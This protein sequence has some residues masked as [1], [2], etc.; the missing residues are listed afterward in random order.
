M[1]V[2]Q[3]IT[4]LSTG[5][6]ETMLLKLLARLHGGDMEC[7]VISLTD[8]GEIGPRIEALGVPV[9]AL[10]MRRGSLDLRAV[11]RLTRR[12]RELQPDVVHTW[13][14]HADLI[15]GISARLAGIRRLSWCIRNSDLDP[16]KSKPATRAVVKLNALLSGVL[17]ARIVCCA[18]SALQV[19]AQAGYD[20]E[21]MCVIPNGF[22][23]S[24]FAP[25]AADRASVRQELGLAEGT[26]LVGLMAR[27]DPQKNH[28]GF[29]MAA[30]RVLERHPDVHFVLAGQSVDPSNHEMNERARQLG[31]S[32]HLHLLG[33]REDMPRLVASLDVL[34]SASS[35]GEAF[36]N[37][38]GEAMASG[39]PCAVTDVGDSASIVGSCGRVV[40]ANDMEGLAAAIASLLELAPQEHA[41]LGH[42]AR[43]RVVDHFEIG[44]VAQQYAALYRQLAARN[45]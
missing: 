6:A 32:A 25:S 41:E 26:P 5:G 27:Y 29:L 10:G 35:Y 14:Y 43:Q 44:R 18:E 42:R 34:A 39:V 9:E 7:H 8:K 21:R 13:M 40:K 17:P 3:I 37:V 4:G 12:L 36:P 19:H 16:A 23:V 28:A 2:V 31:I 45:E 1:K 30:A 20:R 38:L 22:D 11:W 33:R 15:G 24:R